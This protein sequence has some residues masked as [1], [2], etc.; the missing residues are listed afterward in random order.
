MSSGS[1]EI[2][3]A[4]SLL[5]TF[6]QPELVPGDRSQRC[7]ICLQGL[8]AC[9]RY[10]AYVCAKCADLAVDG[11][12][13]LLE[14]VMAGVA[15]GQTVRGV[16][17]SGTAIC[18]IEGVECE[19][20]EARFGGYVI[21][22]VSSEAVTLQDVRRLSVPQLLSMHSAL[23]EELRFRKI[24]RTGNNPTGD[25]VEW[26]VAS[27]L[28]L[29][30]ESNSAKGFDAVDG[31]GLRYQIKGRRLTSANASMQLGVIRALEMAHFDYLVVVVMNPDW[32]IRFALKIPHAAISSIAVYR[33]HV[34]G[35]VL[36]ITSSVL[37]APGV[38]DIALYFHD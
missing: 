8:P 12:G 34:N 19:A 14:I 25:Y 4:N 23:L 36:T 22:P 26:L 11:D 38:E 21:Q 9:A 15:G 24:V 18:F 29:K 28:G 13:N 2:G 31:D 7:P 3:E 5:Q 30:L 10:P 33:K 27:R 35:H 37:E 20:G 17:D 16:G 1:S 32:S 6:Y